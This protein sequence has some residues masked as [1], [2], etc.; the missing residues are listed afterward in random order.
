MEN[1]NHSESDNMG[2]RKKTN[3]AG[4]RGLQLD[5]V[6][7]KSIKTD[8][9]GILNLNNNKQLLDCLQQLNED[10]KFYR[11]YY[12]SSKCPENLKEFLQQ[13]TIQEI[14]Q[15]CLIVPEIA[16]DSIPHIMEDQEYFDPG[17]H[18]SVFV[19][20]HNRYTPAFMH[21]HIF[22]ELVYVLKGQC[23]QTLGVQTLHIGE[24]DICMIAPD[25]YHTIEVFDNSFVLNILI[26][27][28]TFYEV[29]MPLIQGDDPLNDFFSGG[30]YDT[31]QTQYLIFHTEKDEILKNNFI[32]M[33][34]EQLFPDKY[35]NQMLSGILTASIAHLMRYYKET[36]ESSVSIQK[37]SSDN[38]QIL[39]YIQEHLTE[40]TLTDVADHFGF[41]VSYCSRLIKSTTGYGFKDLK[42][43]MRLRKA[44][45]LLINTNT[46]IAE[47][48]DML[49]YA[50]PETFI[51]IFKKE[52]HVSPSQYRRRTKE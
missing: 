44:E 1:T 42:R 22:F 17:T 23:T 15:R 20:R 14:R 29:F 51:R 4:I 47:I 5:S 32:T 27:R 37:N 16:P 7:L 52:F 26:R 18:K 30:L 19:S 46:T 41:S 10:E 40:V 2:T 9:P 13:Y 12:E 3:G 24:G 38:F 48:S 25:T 36:M 39:N 35:T 49:G 33:Y 45:T 43:I 11:E 28:G 6:Q 50:N 8:P 21:K 34:R 31:N